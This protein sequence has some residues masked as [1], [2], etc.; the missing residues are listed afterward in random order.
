MGTGLYDIADRA[1][2][3]TPHEIEAG[4]LQCQQQGIDYIDG[5]DGRATPL[6]RFVVMLEARWA[7][8]CRTARQIENISAGYCSI[9]PKGAPPD[10]RAVH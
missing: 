5:P 4:K 3:F 6:Q 7:R 8:C 10:S 1:E 9:T 2:V